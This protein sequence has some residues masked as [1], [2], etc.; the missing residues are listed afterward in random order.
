ELTSAIVMLLVAIFFVSGADAASVVMG[1]LSQRGSLSPS[2]WIVIF[3]GAAT[4]AVAAVMLAIGGS[5]A[6][7]GIQNLTFIAALPF[8]VVMVAMCFA[9]MKDLLRDPVILVESKATE[10]LEAAVVQ[11]IEQHDGEFQ[12]ELSPTQGSSNGSPASR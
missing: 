1:S 9:L 5:T 7:S 10:V 4:G 12:I 6:L 11:G 8:T 3:W 2:R